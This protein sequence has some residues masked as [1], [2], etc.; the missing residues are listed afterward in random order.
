[1]KLVERN[2]KS[3]KLITRWG[4][5]RSVF[6]GRVAYRRANRDPRRAEAARIIRRMIEDV[7]AKGTNHA[8]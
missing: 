1:M 4:F 6:Y 8:D 3:T 2:G 7:I 5:W